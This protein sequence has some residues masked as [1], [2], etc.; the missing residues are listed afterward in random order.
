[1]Q[2]QEDPRVLA[3]REKAESG[4]AEA[5]FFYGQYLSNQNIDEAL[6]WMEKA[7]TPQAH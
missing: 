5:C 2:S 7:G 6:S 3:L 4:D 1:M